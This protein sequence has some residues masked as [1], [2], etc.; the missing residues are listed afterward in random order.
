[1]NLTSS[2]GR[3][4]LLELRNGLN[5]E[6]NKKKTVS[7]PKVINKKQPNVIELIKL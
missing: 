5:L 1:V 6:Q 3:S 7:K 4:F 2:F